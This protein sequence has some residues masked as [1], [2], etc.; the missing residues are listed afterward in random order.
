MQMKQFLIEILMN[1]V[2]FLFTINSIEINQAFGAG[3]EGIMLI[4]AK[5]YHLNICE[6]SMIGK[7]I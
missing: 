2:D 5:K 6:L 1:S 3:S 4:S 7:F